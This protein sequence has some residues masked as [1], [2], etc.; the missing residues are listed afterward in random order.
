M[1]CV[2]MRLHDLSVVRWVPRIPFPRFNEPR[3]GRSVDPPDLSRGPN[4]HG[5]FLGDLSG[6]NS[7]Y[8]VGRNRGPREMNGYIHQD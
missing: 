4:K 5:K 7:S 2:C 6:V 3:P 8:Y 1:M